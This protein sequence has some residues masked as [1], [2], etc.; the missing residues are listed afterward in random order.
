MKLELMGVG[1]GSTA[2]PDVLT[3]IAQK[4]KNSASSRLGFQNTWL[5]QSR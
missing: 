5:S 2:G 4:V 1:S 3:Q